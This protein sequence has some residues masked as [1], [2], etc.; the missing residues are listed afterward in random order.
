VGLASV[1]ALVVLIVAAVGLFIKLQPSPPPLALPHSAASA[2]AGLADGSWNVEAGS[3]AGFRVPE[4]ALGVVTT[5][6][7]GPG[8]SPVRSC[9]R[10]TT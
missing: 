8:P 7:A 9:S 3:V 4:S 10:A 5:W 1:A 6:S 2:P